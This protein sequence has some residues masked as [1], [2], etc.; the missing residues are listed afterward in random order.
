MRKS[1]QK[2]VEGPLRILVFASSSS[3]TPEAYLCAARALGRECARRGHVI[4]NGG[5][6]A[7][8]MGALNGACR[9]EGG[10][11][12]CVIHELFCV[13]GVEF[14][15][16]DEMIVARGDDLGERK[17]LL[18]SRADVILALPGGVGTLD[19][20]CEAAAL[21]QL[22]MSTTKPVAL[23]NVDGYYEGL[24]AQLDRAHKD[25]LLSKNPASIIYAASN[26]QDALAFCEQSLN[27]HAKKEPS[28]QRRNTRENLLS[29]Y[30]FDRRFGLG[31]AFGL[32][33]SFL[34][35]KKTT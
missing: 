15:G 18:A 31:L 35:S 22:H 3:R 27:G 23:L 21:S 4:V 14:K 28:K 8:G 25:G 7:G 5:G 2:M 34:L 20:L 6:Q 19:E 13:D 16:A 10:K 24:L 17:R 30:V 9:A 33:F 11:I 26:V 29:S 32:L 12:V 1:R